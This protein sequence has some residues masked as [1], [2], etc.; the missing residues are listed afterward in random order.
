MSRDILKDR[1]PGRAGSETVK[2]D[3]YEIYTTVTLQ[4]KQRKEMNL[5]GS[6]LEG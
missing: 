2:L 5:L 1:Y 4:V 3:E 6:R